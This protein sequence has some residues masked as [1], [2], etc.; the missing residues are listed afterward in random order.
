MT[1]NV[2]SV[3]HIADTWANFDLLKPVFDDRFAAWRSAGSPRRS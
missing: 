2:P 1:G 3:Y